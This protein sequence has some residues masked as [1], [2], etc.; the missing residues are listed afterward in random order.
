MARVNGSELNRGWSAIPYFSTSESDSTASERNAMITVA[1]IL[2]H[3]ERFAPKQFAASWDNV[4]LLLGDRAA[5][6][7]KIMTCLTVTPESAA[8][9]VAEQ[10]QLIVSH[11][12]ILFRPVARL[13]ADTPDGRLLL[14]LIRAGVAVYSPHTA[15]D[16][17]KDGINDMLAAALG[18]ASGQ[19]LRHAAGAACKLVVFVPDMDLSKVSA[20]LFAAGAGNIGQYRECSFRLAGTGTFHGSEASN[21]TVGQKGRR[22]EVS[23]W[24]LEV[25]CPEASVEQVVAAMKQAHSYEEPA[26]DVYPLRP[27]ASTSGEGR[28]GTLQK[29]APL[30]VLAGTIRNAL[31][32]GPVQI[33]GDL[34]REV[35]TVAI[36]CGA[37]GEL[38]QDA[39]RARADVFLTGELRFH[40]YLAAQAAG[41]ALVLPGHYATER[42]GVEQLVGRLQQQWPE[43]KVWASHRERDPVAW[44]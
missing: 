37:G 13:T 10:A 7:T 5:P 33:V 29:S 11:H 36:V 38:L 3:L 26:Y 35:A 43:V 17:T 39:I 1:A 15:F 34:G 14:S 4:G 6:V 19:P 16:N 12:P 32:S 8:E 25:V 21:P 9:A 28:L 41:I 40:D 22:E 20:A 24:R 30:G 31:Q 42:L 44:V 18:L 27:G 23:E 2:D